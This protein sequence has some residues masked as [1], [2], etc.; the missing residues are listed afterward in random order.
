MPEPD[1]VTV[2]EKNFASWIATAS[3][4][5]IVVIL[6]AVC[7][8][9]IA[10]RSGPAGRAGTDVGVAAETLRDLLPPPPAPATGPRHGR[11]AP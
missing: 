1:R 8:E 7:Y 4:G 3:L 6:D 10:N 11:A 2:L 5:E 9:L